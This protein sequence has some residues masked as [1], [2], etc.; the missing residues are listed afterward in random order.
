MIATGVVGYTANVTEPSIHIDK[1]ASALL[2]AVLCWSVYWLFSQDL[3]QYPIDDHLWEFL[4][5]VVGTLGAG[6][7]PDV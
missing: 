2:N 1:T 7:V 5:F 4:A 6:P 3:A